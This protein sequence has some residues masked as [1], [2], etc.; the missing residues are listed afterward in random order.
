MM[1]KY[2]ALTSFFILSAV[3]IESKAQSYLPASILVGEGNV[4]GIEQR[5]SLPSGEIT[6]QEKNQCPMTFD[7]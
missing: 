2:L 5:S 6:I 3:S 4:V 7:N 1:S